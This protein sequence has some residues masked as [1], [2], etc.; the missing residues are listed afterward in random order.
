MAMKPELQ[1]GYV[2][3]Q[4]ED[5]AGQAVPEVLVDAVV[6]AGEPP[7]LRDVAKILRRMKETEA[8][9]FPQVLKSLN[10]GTARLIVG[11]SGAL[12]KIGR[13][14]SDS[15]G[16][17]SDILYGKRTPRMLERDSQRLVEIAYASGTSSRQAFRLLNYPA[18]ADAFDKSPEAVAAEFA[19][20]A[21]ICGRK[22]GL[23]FD[24]MGKGELGAVFAREP[25]RALKIAEAGA[26][27]TLLHR[28][29]EDAQVRKTAASGDALKELGRFSRVEPISEESTAQSKAKEVPLGLAKYRNGWKGGREVAK[30]AGVKGEDR[31]VFMNFA[32]A[33]DKVGRKKA[34]ALHREFGIEYFARYSKAELEGMY[35]EAGREEA[36][37][38]KVVLIAY[39]KYDEKMEMYAEKAWRKGLSE[40]GAKVIFFEV[41]NEDEFYEITKRMSEKYLVIEEM[42]VAGEKIG[43][44]TRLGPG[45][46]EEHFLDASDV[47]E[48]RLMKRIVAGKGRTA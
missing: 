27:T 46:G 29:K 20:A 26:Y 48:Q 47:K 15:H 14:A 18:V 11:H 35:K 19:G 17:F 16:V 34:V 41:G 10:K 33:L 1:P 24:L 7:K 22:A 25:A 12:V 32:Y 9:A 4:L 23:F 38:E 5:A 42:M 37:L 31:E 8:E 43:S 36:S 13:Y 28:M 2:R 21:R 45:E 39:A 3:E 44:A 6:E 40:S 30:E